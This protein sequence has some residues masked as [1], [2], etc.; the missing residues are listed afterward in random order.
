MFKNPCQKVHTHLCPPK[1]YLSRLR[2]Y[3]RHG[4]KNARPCAKNQ[5]NTSIQ[6]QSYYI[7]QNH[8]GPNLPC[9]Q[10]TLQDPIPTV[11]SS[12]RLQLLECFH[13]DPLSW[14][15]GRH[16]TYRQL[17]IDWPKLSRDVQEHVQNFHVIQMY[18]PETDRQSTTNCRP[19]AL[20]SDRSGY[21]GS[22]S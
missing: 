1:T 6:V 2:Q 18:R 5:R 22:I 13:H 3:E 7:I 11:H 17:Q 12:F 14:H 21:D 10:T 16:K 8:G 19:T 4:R 15:L 20:R 9:C